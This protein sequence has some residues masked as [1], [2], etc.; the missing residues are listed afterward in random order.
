MF[1]FNLLKRFMRKSKEDRSILAVLQTRY[2]HLSDIRVEAGETV[3]RG[4]L[5]GYSGNTGRSSGPHLHFELRHVLTIPGIRNVDT[6]VLDPLT[7][8]VNYQEPIKGF[9]ESSS[10]YGDRVHPITG[11]ISFHAG[12][13]IPAEEGTPVYTAMS[14]EVVVAALVGNYGNVIY[15]NHL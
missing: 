6:K 10:G 5:I 4:Q 3:E 15:I 9:G 12:V 14:G 8:G 2:A 7:V 1:P 11:N 13:D